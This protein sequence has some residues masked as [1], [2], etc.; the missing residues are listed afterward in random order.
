MKAQITIRHLPNPLLSPN[1]RCHWLAKNRATQQLKEEVHYLA[2]EAKIPKFKAAI[3]QYKFVLPDKRSRDIDNLQI[4]LKPA[5]DALTN[6]G[7]FPDDS[8]KFLTYAPTTVEVSPTKEA[9]VIIT[10]KGEA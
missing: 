7:I 6:L 9:K 2:L 5:I 3:V 10:I 4:S 8:Y 1:A